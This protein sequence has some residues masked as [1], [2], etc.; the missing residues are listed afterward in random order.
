[1]VI[2]K[3]KLNRISW[4]F[5]AAVLVFAFVIA[6]TTSCGKAE[7]DASSKEVDKEGI[8]EFEG[9]VE[10]EVGKYIYIPEAGG[11]DIVIQGNLESENMDTLE[12]KKVRG[13]GRIDENNPSSLIAD[14]LEVQDEEGGW[15]NIFTRT[16]EP[17]LD[18]YVS[19]EQREEFSPIEGLAYNKKD[20]W[21]GKEKAKVY[22][23]L[24]ETE[25]GQ[26]IIVYDPESDE[27]LGSIIVDNITDFTK[28]Y[29]Q[30]LR[31]FDKLY[32]YV[33][34]KETVDWSVRRRTREMFHADVIFA[35]LY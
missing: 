3:T 11:F 22:G 17:V 32:F 23:E 35:G 15:R 30:K 20:T 7:R 34:L 1:M 14:T 24:S 26:K 25:E 5:C 27:E 6:G 33:Y 10:V 28:F 12:G 16:E 31:L 18:D 9:T 29:I 2:E 19:P 8:I 21:E 13:E 4:M